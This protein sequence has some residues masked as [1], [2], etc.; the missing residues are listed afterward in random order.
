MNCDKD[1]KK[2]THINFEQIRTL[3]SVAAAHPYIP[4]VSCFDDIVQGLHRLLNWCLRIEAVALQHVDVIELEAFERF[5]HR[6]KD[7]LRRKF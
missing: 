4:D 3:P 7:M 1:Q 2:V 5:L 6:V